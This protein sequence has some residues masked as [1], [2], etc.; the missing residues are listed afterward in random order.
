MNHSLSLQSCHC[1]CNVTSCVMGTGERVC[2]NL[3][4]CFQH[5]DYDDVCCGVSVPQDRKTFKRI[6]CGSASRKVWND[7]VSLLGALY[8]LPDAYLSYGGSVRGLM[9]ANHLLEA[10]HLVPRPWQHWSLA[11]QNSAQ[12]SLLLENAKHHGGLETRL[13]SCRVWQIC[14]LFLQRQM[15]QSFLE[16]V[17][18]LKTLEVSAT[19][20]FFSCVCMCSC[21]CVPF[22]SDRKVHQLKYPKLIVVNFHYFRYVVWA[23]KTQFWWLCIPGSFPVS[24]VPRPCED[25]L[26]PRPNF[27]VH[28]AVSSKKK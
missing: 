9:S 18:M 25:S 12:I 8:L 11:V 23:I 4:V 22:S 7:L 3:L 5:S 6:I 1:C 20:F 13:I 21:V 14:H 24:L 28:P 17:P 26:I 15:Y 16:S 19:C 10:R 2:G 27:C